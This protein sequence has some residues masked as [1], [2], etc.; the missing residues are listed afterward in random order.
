M[1]A[2]GVTVERGRLCITDALPLS[3]SLH[4]RTSSALTFNYFPLLA[5]TTYNPRQ[6]RACLVMR[7][8]CLPNLGPRTGT[9][10]PNRTVFGHFSWT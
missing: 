1:V 4:F 6:A 2:D 5:S 7:R 8:V 3:R 9:P 10:L